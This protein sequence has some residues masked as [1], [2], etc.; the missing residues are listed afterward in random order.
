MSMPNAPRLLAGLALA[1]AVVG[2]TAANEKAKSTGT[3]IVST[4]IQSSAS[5]T[6]SLE[7]DDPAPQYP[8][9]IECTL[10]YRPTTSAADG[11][12]KIVSVKRTSNLTGDEATEVMGEF[13]FGVVYYGDV[14]EGENVLVSVRHL[15]DRSGPVGQTT[16]TTAQAKSAS[17]HGFTGFQRLEV[18]GSELQ[19]WCSST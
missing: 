14:P 16:Y 17:P 6:P 4:A 12:T 9:S 2:C 3:E 10:F 19:W 15:R 8:A 7:T 11:D 18:E 5:T 1:V 13:S